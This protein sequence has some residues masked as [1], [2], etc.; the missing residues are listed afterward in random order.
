MGLQRRASRMPRRVGIA[1]QREE[2]E[3][4]C[5]SSEALL[6]HKQR[7]SDESEYPTTILEDGTRV[8]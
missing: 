8:L 1:C 5:K 4:R 7:T 3:L 2:K 6:P